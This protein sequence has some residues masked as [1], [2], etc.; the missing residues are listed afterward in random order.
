MKNKI[1]SLITFASLTAGFSAH[2]AAEEVTV[3]EGDTLWEIAKLNEVEV[4]NIIDWNKLPG[5]IIHPNDQLKLHESHEVSTGETLW[6]I[7]E[8]Y[9]VDIE[10]IEA[11]NKIDSHIIKP[12]DELII[13][14]NEK[15]QASSEDKKT[16]S[17]KENSKELTVTATAYTANCEGCSGTTKMG[18]DLHANPDKKVIAVDPDVIPL[19]STVEVE[20]YGT[21]I[22]ADTGGAIKGNKIDVFI[23][24]ESDALQWGKQQV[25][26][27][28]IEE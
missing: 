7:A 3:K 22:A 23:P 14:E 26:V 17:N 21:A 27:K 1:L 18:I 24:S 25:E 11:W 8:E 2:A 15:A 13:K 12:G 28:I 19:G 16:E 10:E 4:E 5:D 6:D 9:D 20:G